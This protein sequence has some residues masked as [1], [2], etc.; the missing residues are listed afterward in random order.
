MAHVLECADGFRCC[1]LTRAVLL[2][3]EIGSSLLSVSA[4]NA[5]STILDLPAF[6]A[7]QDEKSTDGE[8]ETANHDR[9]MRKLNCGGVCM[10]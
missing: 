1:R 6:P 7:G 10:L 9:H 2:I 5:D 8:I 3:N 4:D